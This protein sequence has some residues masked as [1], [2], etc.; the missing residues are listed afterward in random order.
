MSLRGNE[1]TPQSGSI[2]GPSTIMW[3]LFFSPL[4]FCDA[5]LLIWNRIVMQVW[6]FEDW[7]FF[8]GGGRLSESNRIGSQCNF[9]PRSN[10]LGRLSQA[11]ASIGLFRLNDANLGFLGHEWGANI[12]NS[13]RTKAIGIKQKAFF[14]PNDSEDQMFTFTIVK[15]AL[16]LLGGVKKAVTSY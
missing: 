10:S 12:L 8:S 14:W 9:P 4:V 15:R 5:Y 16:N 13:D 3:L 6:S 7:L 2:W 1:L 11:R